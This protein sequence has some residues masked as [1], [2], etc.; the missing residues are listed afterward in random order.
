MAKIENF[1]PYV[2]VKGSVVGLKANEQR[3]VLG[4]FGIDESRKTLSSIGK[5][6]GLSRERIRQIEK[7]GLKKMAKNI[8]DKENI[9]VE[10][11]IE[12]FKKS[13]GV[14]NHDSIAEKF[15]EEKL[16]SNKNEINSLGLIFYLIPQL[17]KID[18]TREL[19]NGW[20]LAEIDKKEAS[21]ILN[22][23]EKHLE[24]TKKPATIEVL[25]NAHPH[26]SK[27]E[28]TFLSELPSVSKKIVKTESG[29]IGL[30]VWPEVNPKNVR[31][32]IYFILKKENKPMHFGDISSKIN[33]EKFS[34]RKVVQ[35]T[36][37]NELIADDRFVL[38]GRGIYALKEWGYKPGTVFDIIRQI[39]EEKGS[40]KI[41]D[42]ISEVSKQR[43]VKKNTILINLQTK[44]EF[45]KIGRESY[46]LK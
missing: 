20:L 28:I 36:V 3:V 4:R 19:E 27:Y 40:M 8:I 26:H 41:D 11:I 44:K 21:K 33:K 9:Y 31:D 7:E 12:S 37:H 15:L 17:K 10:K 22:D 6:L 39:L 38:V 13:G 29:F 45:I 30:S 42:I 18:K 14:S 5:E 34:V 32:K 23:W 25:I 35:A 2:I 16:L 46:K 1:S 24:K 43:T